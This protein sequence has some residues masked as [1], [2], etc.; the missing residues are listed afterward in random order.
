MALLWV[1]AWVSSLVS[2]A[3]GWKEDAGTLERW[4]RGRTLLAFRHAAFAL[5]V[6]LGGWL[7]WDRGWGLGYARWFA[8]KV[9]LV[10]FL[11]VPLETFHA[12]V[13]HVWIRR[14]LAQ[15]AGPPFA[16]DLTRGLGIEEMLRTLG[17]PLFGLAVPFL[18]WLSFRRPF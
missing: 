16:K 5:L 6:A 12:Y 17:V 13:T 3:G 7:A 18:L 10:L 9:G 8:V 15:T 4:R 1:A 2:L 11:V 14:G